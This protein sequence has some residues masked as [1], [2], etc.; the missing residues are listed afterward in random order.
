MVVSS[1]IDP[2]S[3]NVDRNDFYGITIVDSSPVEVCRKALGSPATTSDARDANDVSDVRRAR[4][5][6]LLRRPG[7]PGP[8]AHGDREGDVGC[9][10]VAGKNDVSSTGATSVTPFESPCRSRGRVQSTSLPW[11][12]MSVQIGLI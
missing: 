7:L 2:N 10:E 5:R 4:I 12:K 6:K 8:G 1:K 9:G 3:Y 11:E